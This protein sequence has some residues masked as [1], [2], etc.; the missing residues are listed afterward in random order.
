M[1]KLIVSGDSNTDLSFRSV[2]HPEMDFSYKKWPQH[3]AEHLGMELV[4]L[5][6]MGKGNQYIYHSLFDEIIKTPKDEIGLVVAGW[7][8]AMRKDWQEDDRWVSTQ[9]EQDGD[10]L[11]WVNKSLRHFISFQILC[12]KYDLPYIHFQMTDLF[13]AYLGGLQASDEPDWGLP[14]FQPYPG[15]KRKD[16]EKIL[17]RIFEYYKHIN[18]FVGWPGLRKPYADAGFGGFNVLEKLMGPTFDAQME[19]GFQISEEDDHPNE[20]GHK[21]IA[22]LLIKEL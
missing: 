12:E 14:H 21:A 20:A 10:L 18:N 16:E 6:K 5:G 17:N 22:D 19:S 15:D 7:S 4:C 13:E 1:K 11:S 2:F 3:L 9:V 8:Q